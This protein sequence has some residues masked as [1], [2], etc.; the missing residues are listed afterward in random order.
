MQADRDR[1]QRA[2][3]RGARDRLSRRVL[4][5][6][7]A[8]FQRSLGVV[9]GERAEDAVQVAAAALQCRRGDAIQCRGVG[10]DARGG[11]F[12][13]RARR[14]C[15][16][17]EGDGV[18]PVRPLARH[19]RSPRRGA[20]LA[21]DLVQPRR[22][23]ARRGGRA[24]ARAA[25][26]CAPARRPRAGP[27]APAARR[28]KPAPA[29]AAPQSTGT[30][31]SAAWVGVEHATAAT[32]SSSVRS[33]WWPTEEITGTRSSATVRHKVSSQKA[34]R[35]A[36]EP[37]PRATTITSIS[38]QEAR[39]VSARRIAGAAW[40]SCTGAKAQ[41]IRPAQPRRR[42]P[43][44]TSSRAFPDS[45][46]TTPMQRGSTGREQR[47]LRLEQPF[48][49]QPAAQLLE[50][51]QQVALAGHP[52]PRHREREPRRRRP[53]ARVV[54]AAARDDD[55]RPVGQ[56]PE[57][58]LVEVLAPH[59]ARQR[60]GGVA[61][62]EPDLR[63]P[64]LEPEDLPEDLHAREPAQPLAQRRRVRPHGI[65]PGEDRAGD[66]VGRL[67]GPQ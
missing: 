30:A 17:R 52:Q 24:R 55:L 9:G 14:E 39:S 41:T 23:G 21:Q 48:G 38:G 65:G 49:V 26:A 44:R 6:R 59:R 7:V 32:S 12:A 64:R 19:D 57:P 46:V 67:H 50:L 4:E 42:S 58:Q 10:A 11:A 16:A 2:G 31:V 61:Q 15:A 54:V 29:R 18:R 37:P 3:G 66:A 1:G 40:R 25:T 43:A 28:S 8:A 53:R 45:P 20:Q 56:R 27:G 13:R 47:L 62:L 36:S 5:Q 51:R 35:S 60:A 22:G 33:V 63:P 34:N